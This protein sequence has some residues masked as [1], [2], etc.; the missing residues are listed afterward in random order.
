MTI[1]NR[2]V[3]H[4]D[5][6]DT[7]IP[8]DGV[9]KVARPKTDQQWAVL[10]WELRSFV[11]DGEYER[12]LDRILTSYLANLS[13]NQQPAAWVGGFYGSGKSHLCRVLEHLWQDI[14][15]PSGESARDIVELPTDIVAHFVELSTRGK[16][17]GGLWAAAGTLTAGLASAPKLAFLSILFAA[18]GL[19]E[20]YSL[21]RFVMWARKNGYVDALVQACAD[22]GKDFGNELHDLHVSPVIA[23]ALLEI[24]PTL[25]DS[26]KDVRGLLKEDFPATTTDI[27]DDRLFDMI[28]DVLKVQSDTP[29]K[30]PLTL[31]VLD[32]MQQYLGEDN[33]RIGVVQNIVEGVRDRYGS[34][35]LIAATGQSAMGATPTLLRL[36]DRFPVQIHL[37]DND[38]E[39]V[40]RKVILQKKPNRVGTVQDTLEKAS[41][42]I[43]RH[44]AGSSIAPKGEDKNDLVADY[45]LLPTRR[46]FWELALRGIDRAGKAGVLRTQLRIIH[47]AARSVAPDPIGH[48]VG[49]DF[50]YDQQQAGM[51][52][53]GVL[54]REIDELIRGLRDQGD[55]GLL[56]S[57]ICAMVFLIA[58]LPDRT[59]SGEV[60][61]E[62]TEKVIADLLVENLVDGGTRIRRSI[63]A[64]L[65][66]L[67]QQGA[68]MRVGEVH[69][70]QT[71][72]GAEWERDYQSRL[73]ALRDDRG[74]IAMLRN[75][76]LVRAIDSELNGLKLAQGKSA[77]ARRIVVTYGDQKPSA[78]D[79]GVPI[80]VQD[81]WNIS[82][83]DVRDAA[84]HAG[85][86]SPIVHV[87]L[88]KPDDAALRQSLAARTAAQEVIDQKPTPQTEEG[89]T[90]QAAMRTRVA[91]MDNRLAS[92]VAS[93]VVEAR[94]FQGG[95]NE[96]SGKGLREV[97][98][99]AAEHAL[100]R[101][102]P[103]FNDVD[104]PRWSTVI[105]KARDGAPD[106]LSAI[107]HTGDPTTHPVCRE[108]LAAV[109][110]AGIK[111]LD[112][113]KR[114]ID[115]PYGWPKDAVNGAL[116]TLLAGSYVRA[117]QEGKNLTSAKQLVPTQIGKTTFYREDKPPTASQRM[118]V[119]GLLTAAGIPYEN[120]QEHIQV[121]VLLQKL[122][123]IAAEAGG[124]APLP[125]PPDIS[126]VLALQALAGNQQF[127]EAADQQD[128]LKSD[129]TAWRNAAKERQIRLKDWDTLES[130]LHHARDLPE[131]VEIAA[132]R[133][134]ILD[135]QQ[136]LDEPNPVLPL[137]DA[138]IPPLREAVLSA[139]E[140]LKA[141]HAEAVAELEAL[142]E[143]E[144]LDDD[145]WRE[146]FTEIGF[147]PPQT[148]DV[149]N[150]ANL[151]TV[152]T[153]APLDSWKDKIEVVRARARRA[154]E[155]AA[156]RLAP[157][158]VQV[159]PEPA[160]LSTADEV[161]AY[162]DGLR[163]RLA[164]HIEA[165]E[166]VI[167]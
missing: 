158:A 129:L 38:V 146:I 95:G 82:A 99:T 7:K 94:V 140:S 16:Q 60:G 101:L 33:E 25:G 105:Q 71:E 91:A 14:T 117:A 136:L 63:P 106:A 75:E 84:A 134:A 122:I 31:V 69:A 81:E 70:L 42:E 15:L 40:V 139:V 43:N 30:L 162:V 98:Q 137:V 150:R 28:E 163:Q 115:P 23:N 44:L 77:T 89:K 26:A 8:N 59:L 164:K 156:R 55:D 5:P 74:R 159:T 108:V 79:D 120:G 50:I 155:M 54:L 96:L 17:A 29:G 102:F 13:Q 142:D 67:V 125:E 85:D 109:S 56:K 144:K 36:T 58:Q 131:A 52:G 166:T 121:P 143:W 97:V 92:L 154:R 124:A 19:P 27:D 130:L 151:L 127:R 32:E 165:G 78:G 86:E 11:C 37:R 83:S 116:L 128:Q 118:A 24:D 20:Q 114:F 76:R 119:R 64:L 51:L 100:I 149:S 3:F 110:A 167:I 80:W 103:R 107:D 113:Q 132:Q 148:V 66:E 65:E 53:S 133:R 152:L 57:R 9:A 39:T 34:Q 49:A 68:L 35:V 90:A 153:D 10:D 2:E 111:G 135:D 138:I 73:T 141:H 22:A 12:G 61:V 46:R 47:E 1:L 72:E 104:D 41:G 4:R 157:K 6:T 112:L 93:I 88:P 123:D 126:L 21:A 161:D 87:L 145:A 147:S 160:T 48:V 45:P 18:A 62:A